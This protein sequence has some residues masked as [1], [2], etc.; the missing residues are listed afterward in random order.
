[1]ANMIAGLILLS[2]G[3]IILANVFIST[4]KN[5]NTTGW[6]TGERKAGDDFSALNRSVG[7]ADY[8]GYCRDAPGYPPGF[9]HLLSVDSEN[10]RAVAVSAA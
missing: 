7:Y 1:M 8:R 5:T 9:R 3:V 6:T 2:I 4:V 10:V